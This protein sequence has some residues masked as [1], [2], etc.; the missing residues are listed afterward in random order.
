MESKRFDYVH[1]RSGRR[2]GLIQECGAIF[3]KMEGGGGK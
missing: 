1:I 3:I 2:E